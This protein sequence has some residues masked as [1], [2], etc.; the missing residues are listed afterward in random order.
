MTAPIQSTTTGA[1]AGYGEPAARV[2]V[3]NSGLSEEEARGFN[4]VF[5]ASFVGFTFIAI[6]AHFLVWQW[7]PWI[8]GARGYPARTGGAQ[9]G[10]AMQSHSTLPAGVVLASAQ[11]PSTHR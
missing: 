3:P 6:V 1:Y 9:T 11:A 5:F 7:R 4:S 2:A 8:P 10:A